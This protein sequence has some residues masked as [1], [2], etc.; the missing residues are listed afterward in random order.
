MLCANAGVGLGGAFLDQE[1]AAVRRLIET[2]VIGT[3]DLVQQV[4]RRM[5]A[6]GGGRILLTGS[7]AGL[8]PGAY[9]AAYSASKAFI[10]NFSFGLRNELKD[11]GVTVTSLM[12]SIT[13][14]GFWA[15][16]GRLGSRAASGGKDPPDAPAKAGWAAMKKGKGAVSPSYFGI[17][18]RAIL[19]MLPRDTLAEA[20]AKEMRLDD[21]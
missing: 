8:L 18:E 11:S 20:N 15:R 21:E 4:G 13:D 9:S 5:R 2:D 6:R 19:R 17:L 14:T 1:F 10:D 7:I 3:I 16:S 12:P